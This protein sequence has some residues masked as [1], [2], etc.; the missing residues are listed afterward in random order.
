[1]MP[2]VFHIVEPIIR[3]WL[4]YRRLSTIYARI[5]E[6]L[7]RIEPS[8]PI[9]DDSADIWTSPLMNADKRCFGTFFRVGFYGSR[10]G[11]LDGEEF[12]Y[13]EPP[14]TKL[15]EISHRLESFYTDRFGKRGHYGNIWA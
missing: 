7:G 4:D 11:D 10:F 1:M 8:L 5:S 15:S 12:V 9:V 6:A 3:E 2:D 13:K 14:F